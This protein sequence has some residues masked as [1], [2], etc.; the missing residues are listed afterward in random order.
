[1][2]EE[3]SCDKGPW[4]QLL[5]GISLSRLAPDTVKIVTPSWTVLIVEKDSVLI[6]RTKPRPEVDKDG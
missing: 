3:R 2:S 4:A 6:S 1:M 5:G